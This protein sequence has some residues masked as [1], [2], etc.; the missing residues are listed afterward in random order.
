MKT[1]I[2]TTAIFIFMA[3]N[4]F[5]QSNFLN[6]QLAD[7]LFSKTK[8]VFV[9]DS[10]KKTRVTITKNSNKQNLH[11]QIHKIYYG[12]SI[13][14]FHSGWENGRVPE[15]STAYTLQRHEFRLN[16]IGRSSYAFNN[17]LEISSYLP[18]MLFMRNASI[19][20]RFLDK[21]FIASSIELGTAHGLFPA[22]VATGIVFPGAAIGAATAGFIKGSDNHIKLFY[23]WKP[24]NKL[25]F[26]AR[27]SVSYLKIG[28]TG[29]GGFAA[30]GNEGVVAGVLP[31]SL[32]HR[33]RY[34]MGGFESDYV[35]NKSN[36]IVLN[37]S[38][39]GFANG[40]KQL[41]VSSLAWTHA[42]KAHFH[43][44]VGLYN[45]LD[46]PQWD[47]WKDA[48]TKLPVGVYGNIYWTFNN[49]VKK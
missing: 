19:K 28:Y 45:F 49:R 24:S 42:N 4:A 21:K 22:A 23:S 34:F 15:F 31:I 16:V 33:F 46:P 3:L 27:A 26:S 36:V 37:S 40:K 39:S 11:K 43:F 9:L 32:N 14:L 18:L 12:D 17:R 41:L 29:I 1:I 35:I 7:S 48:K 38:I 13:T 25:T 44:T 47:M 10:L 20:Y 2:N 8:K 30:L 5:S 6:R